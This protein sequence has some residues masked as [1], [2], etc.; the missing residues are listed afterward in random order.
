MSTLK[1]F[2]VVARLQQ[3]LR[4]N[5]KIPGNSDKNFH[6]RKLFQTPEKGFLIKNRILA[7]DS[8]QDVVKRV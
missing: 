2:I 4:I 7:E 8:R 5:N 3:Q 6:R 1:L